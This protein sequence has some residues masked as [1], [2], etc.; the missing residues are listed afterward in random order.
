M[1][2]EYKARVEERKKNLQK[3]EVLKV[4]DILD[5][6]GVER[7]C[8][9][10]MLLSHVELVDGH[11]DEVPIKVNVAIPPH[12]PSLNPLEMSTPS[13]L[14]KFYYE[15]TA[16]V[17]DATDANDPRRILNYMIFEA[18]DGSLPNPW[19]DPNPDQRD[20]DADTRAKLNPITSAVEGKRVIMVD[21]SIVRGTTMGRI[22]GLLKAAGAMEVHVRIGVPPIVAPCPLGID[23]KTKDQFLARG[24]SEEEIARIIGADSV[25]YLSMAGLEE[26]IGISLGDLCC[27]CLTEE[28][29]VEIPDRYTP[30]GIC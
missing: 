13:G 15:S 25:G 1:W 27:G 17:E 8:C 24:R 4:G 7:Y 19:G 18:D 22:V 9:R 3:G 16:P 21:D 2:E 23:M 20:R 5:D 14:Q 30:E 28:Y 26:A 12:Q 6:L 11:L 29:P 10:R